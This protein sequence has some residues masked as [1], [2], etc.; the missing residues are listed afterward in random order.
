MKRVTALRKRDGLSQAAL[1]RRAELNNSTVNA[2]ES[3]RLNPWPGQ[4]AKLAAAL[5]WPLE[6]AASLMDEVDSE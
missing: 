3:G 5:A 1:A 6:D 4:L 2:I